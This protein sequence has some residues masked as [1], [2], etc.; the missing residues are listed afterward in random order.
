M[1]HNPPF[2]LERTCMPAGLGIVNV[3][4]SRAVERDRV[5]AREVALPNREQRLALAVD[6][7]AAAKAHVLEL[8]VHK[9]EALR[10]QDVA[11]VD[12]AVEELRRSVD[13]LL[14][15]LCQCL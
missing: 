6:S 8:V 15:L 9:I 12:E 5:L 11:R 3:V 1:P 10:G 2:S 4:A 13:S 14:L 7:T